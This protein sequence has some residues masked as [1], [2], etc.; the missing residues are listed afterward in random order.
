MLT[1]QVPVL[2]RAVDRSRNLERQ[3]QVHC[4]GAHSGAWI[5]RH[6][7]DGEWDKGAGGKAADELKSYS[8]PH[9]SGGL[10]CIRARKQGELRT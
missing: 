2:E 8:G 1:T 3:F 6:K 7:S 9:P 10:W 5:L 4:I